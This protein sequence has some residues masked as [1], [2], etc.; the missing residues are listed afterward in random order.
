M[1]SVTSGVLIWNLEILL[2]Q[3]QSE[4]GWCTQSKNGNVSE[5]CGAHQEIGHTKKSMVRI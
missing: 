4:M 1:F 3:A 2:F 5:S